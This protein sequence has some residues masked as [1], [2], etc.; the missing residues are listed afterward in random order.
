[1][2]LAKA[3]AAMQHCSQQEAEAQPMASQHRMQQAAPRR[4][5]PQQQH[6]HQLLLPA[7]RGRGRSRAM[8]E[9]TNAVPMRET[10]PSP[11]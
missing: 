2:L 6:R 10:E 1:V 8:E 9:A 11:R 5:R 3:A 4:P 7:S